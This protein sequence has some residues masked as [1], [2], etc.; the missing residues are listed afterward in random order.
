MLLD[1][2]VPM[3]VPVREQLEMFRLAESLGY[4]GAGVADHMEYGRDVFTT[5]TSAA[6]Q[7]DHIALFPCV[8]NPVSRHPWVLANIM[9]TME[10]LAPGRFRMVIGAGDSVP[11]HIGRKPA[12]VAEMRDA[13]VS[14]RKLLRGEQVS[15]GEEPDQGIIGVEPPAPPVIV[16]AGGRRMTEVAGEVADEVFLLTGFDERIIAMAR[17]H[18]ETGAARSG[19]LLDAFKVSHYTVVRIEN[20]KMAAAEFG[21]TRLLGWLKQSFFKSSLL[22]LGVPA[23]ALQHP[24]TIP[25]A[26]LDNLTQALFLIGPVEEISERLLDIARSGRIDRMVCNV[27]GPDGWQ[28]T[29]QAFA[30]SV[31]PRLR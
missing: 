25:A 11:I 29:A 24:E 21:R 27:S 10:A 19:R 3:Q 14:I 26:E 7:T 6:M 23:E 31:L 28:A 30:A 18:L 17:R 15:F 9:H 22:E 4:D 8:S 16:A 20:D 5:L 13:V 12:A 1:I 2:Q